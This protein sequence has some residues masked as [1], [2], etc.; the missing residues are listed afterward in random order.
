M[1]RVINFLVTVFAVFF[2]L[3]IFGEIQMDWLW[4]FS[5]LWI[6]LGLVFIS[7]LGIIITLSLI[8][9]CAK[10]GEKESQETGLYLVT[11]EVK[12]NLIK[13]FL[14]WIGLNKRGN[15]RL[16]LGYSFFKVGEI[17]DSGG[18]KIRILRKL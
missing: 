7:V 13:R 18:G 6:P 11:T 16:R 9:F 17:L 3:K 8:F 10:I 5:P 4:V 15:F 12:E 1:E 2:F 14:R